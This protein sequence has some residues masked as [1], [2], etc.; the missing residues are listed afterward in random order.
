VF[1]NLNLGVIYEKFIKM[2]FLILVVVICSS[3]AEKEESDDAEPTTFLE[4]TWKKA[5]E[6]SSTSKYSEYLYV[7]KNTSY[8]YYDYQYSDSACSTGYV[9]VRYTYTMAVGSDATMADGSTTATKITLTSVGAYV[10]AKTDSLVATLNSN[11]Q[12]SATDWAKNVE[13]DV[14][15]K[16]TEATCLNADDAMG[17]V[18]KRVMKVVG[19]DLWWGTGTSD[20]DSEGYPTVLEDTGFDK[21]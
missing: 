15:S 14:S 7:F 20:K 1:I 4:G 9:T 5:C 2:F 6:Q 16:S 8:T 3:C 11:S 21:Q 10:T 17:T 19:T 13:K 12:C 18:S